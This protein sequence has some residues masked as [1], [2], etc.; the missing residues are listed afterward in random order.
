MPN[1][2]CTDLDKHPEGSEA[3]EG[4]GGC[5][6]CG[7]GGTPRG[8]AQATSAATEEGTGKESQE[9]KERGEGM[10]E[11]EVGGGTPEEGTCRNYLS[12]GGCAP[13]E[14]KTDWPDFVT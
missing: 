1:P 14:E 13:P 9:A 11:E 3:E 7:R 6:G 2:Q 4:E 5:G 10:A 12:G 8:R